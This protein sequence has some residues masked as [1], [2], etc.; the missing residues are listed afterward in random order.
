MTGYSST[1]WMT[2]LIESAP[3]GDPYPSPGVGLNSYRLIDGPQK[4]GTASGRDWYKTR[5]SYRT[6]GGEFDSFDDTQNNESL[7]DQFALCLSDCP[8]LD[9]G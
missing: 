2:A 8:D 6:I 3:Q 9:I 5:Y 1:K 4:I 7:R